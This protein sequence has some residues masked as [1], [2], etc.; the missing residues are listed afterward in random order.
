MLSDSTLDVQ[1]NSPSLRMISVGADGETLVGDDGFEWR[2]LNRATPERIQQ[3]TQQSSLFPLVDHPRIRSAIPSYADNGVLELKLIIPEGLDPMADRL[4][5][6]ASELDLL[7]KLRIAT[8]LV[9]A[10]AAAHRVG[11]YQGGFHA[12]TILVAGTDDPSTAIHID[13]TA[14][15]CSD[16]AFDTDHSIEGDLNGLRDL[17]A[18][19]LADVFNSELPTAVSEHLRGRQRAILK[20][21]LQPSDDQPAPSLGQWKSVLEPFAAQPESVD[22]TGVI[23]TPFIPI[24]TGS[25]SRWTTD[26][27][28]GNR[29]TD[30]PKQL[31]RFQIQELIGEGGMGSVYRAI[32]LSNNE[33]IAIKVL[34][35]GGKDVAHAIRRFRKEARLLGNVQNE[36]IT[37]LIDVGEDAGLHYFAMEFVDGIDLKTWFAERPEL[38][39]SEALRITADLARALVDAHS[40]EV[41][42]R[43]IKPENVLL[44]LRDEASLPNDVP[45]EKRP[46]NDFTLKLTDFGIARHVNQSQSM[47]VTQAGSV[48]G[49]PKYM[50]PEQCKS[51]DS[52]GPA[53]D[54][55]SIGITLFE[56]LTG[57]VPY[58]ADEFMKLAAMH[59][60]DPIPSVQK[61]NAT[62]SDS[63]SRIVQR[64]LAKDPTQR[65]GDASQLLTDLLVL[66]RGETADVQAHPRLPTDHSAK[67]LWEKTASWHLE[68][69]SSDL[70]PLVSNTERLNEAVGLPAVDYRTEK[71]P[72]L[73]IRKFGS[74][75]LS[76]VKVSWEEHPFEWVEGQ[77][78]GILREFDSGPFKWFMSVV[79]LDQHP[80]GGTQ[81]SHQ[82]RIEPRNLLGRVLTTVEADW[83]GFRNLEKVYQ[84]MDRSLRGKL[85]P[86]QGS[87]PFVDTP[88]MSRPQDL[89]LNQR[90][91]QL[92]ESGVRPEVAD[93]LAKVIREWSA[94][95]LASLRPLALADRWKIPSEEMIDACLMAADAGI[96]NLHWEI[97]CP[98]CRVSA[99]NKQQLAEIDTH[100]H[101][102]ACDVDFQS[103]LAGAIEMVFQTHP[104]IR[105]VNAGQYCIGGPEHSPHVV[106]QLRIEAG[107]CLQLPIDLDPGDYLL[108]GP[109]IA[110]TQSLRVQSTSAP[111]TWDGSLSSL[112]TS[113]HIPK[114]RAGRQT[115][116]L[117]NDLETLQ[118]IRIE[119]MIPRGDVVTAAT[120]SANPT[121]R[122]LFPHQRF[123]DNNPIATETMTF[124]A[125]SINNIED[126]YAS[127]GDTEAYS[128]VHGH[129]TIL[130]RCVSGS[131]G[132][133]VKTIGEKSLASFATR[134]N[135]IIAAEHLRAE[136]LDSELADV[137]LGIGIHSGPTL[138]T[139]QNN[140]LDYF[141]GTVRAVVALPELAG[142]GTLL[143][144][145]IYSDRSLADRLT[146]L[147]HQVESVDLPGSP[148]T[149]T[150]RLTLLL[151]GRTA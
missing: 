106:A 124:L 105:E 148:N 138:V 39:E 24:G 16:E 70:W 145:A 81:L 38:T 134:E 73:G 90:L 28:G 87:D 136:W 82:V 115:L 97:L 2:V 135:A 41:I 46:F 43:D 7:A 72:H 54:V 44:K 50:S 96:L 9:D 19:L 118:V 141:G 58:Q 71:D 78:M 23:Q 89:R 62:I 101:C 30:V 113:R 76:G 3:I 34:R 108:R 51:S 57:S 29:V 125:T 126:L 5:N 143:T 128:A 140:Q 66:L 122:K 77:R 55:Y 26:A 107:E 86:K 85:T 8:Q 117:L 53:T 114:L 92:I 109:R 93:C 13:F 20:Q 67:K 94:Q 32:D 123:A 103:N 45:I 110:N 98:T 137:S 25:T 116:T 42:H 35:N 129:H 21:W 40:Q 4:S 84:R 88:K 146:T 22:A 149:R 64:A 142:N 6:R 12:S 52:L 80:D 1:L 95:E 14:T 27:S 139:T 31:G 18:W 17:F 151:S 60:F 83:K 10:C 91:S 104:E 150:K 68:S 131:G 119:R 37:Q 15:H 121:F 36:H 49:T 147:N 33:T 112:G 69:D 59:C 120:A 100:T 79:T 132:T 99:D 133:L 65:Y 63:A 47:E 56:L 102:E 127:L 75:T 130:E 48:M 111:S 11:L 61:R 144:E 74:F